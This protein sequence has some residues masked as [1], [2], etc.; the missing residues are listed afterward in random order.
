M[1]NYTWFDMLSIKLYYYEGRF[2]KLLYKIYYSKIFNC[3]SCN[4]F[5]ISLIIYFGLSFFVIDIDI[6]TYSLLTFLIHKAENV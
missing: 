1:S 3:Q 4:V 2:K 5:W 6:V